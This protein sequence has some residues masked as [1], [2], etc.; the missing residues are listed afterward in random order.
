MG[1]LS[2]DSALTDLGDG[3]FV[4]Q[5]SRDWEIWGP[6]GGYMAAIALQAA[7]VATGRPRPANATVHFL[8]AASFDEPV[9]VTPTVQRSTR[10]A[11]S[12]R[13]AIAQGDRPVLEAMVWALDD[14]LP[15]LHHDGPP[16]PA[17]AAAWRDHPTM[18]ERW[19]AAGVDR[20][21]TYRFW[22]NLEQRP[23]VWIDDWDQRDGLDPVYLDWIRFASP[24][25]D[26][27]WSEAARQLLLVDLGAWPAA[28]RH[29]VQTDYIAPSIDVSCEFHHLGP[30][31]GWYLLRGE[32]PVAGNGLVASHQEV[33]DEHGRLLASGIS[34]LLCRPTR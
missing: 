20:P 33:W 30:H 17:A 21:S 2:V 15:G 25:A 23:P 27:A 24:G 1:D 22:D 7:R 18:D 12:V 26:D 34:H 8:S 16:P 14:E 19:A 4:R 29:H 9:R 32:S 11:T 10:V 6:N 5:L 31:T 3:S 28:N 13:V